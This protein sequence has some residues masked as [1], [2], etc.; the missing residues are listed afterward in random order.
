M[1]MEPAGPV[2]WGEASEPELDRVLS[3]ALL[4]RMMVLA[5]TEIVPL[6][7]DPLV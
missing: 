3:L 4:S 1:F 5:S 7:P 6:L 2:G